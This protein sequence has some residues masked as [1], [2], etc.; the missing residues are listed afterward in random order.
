MARAVGKKARGRGSKDFLKGG[1]PKEV[2]FGFES[3][4]P[5]HVEKKRP[6]VERADVI[7]VE[8]LPQFIKKLRTTSPELA[9]QPQTIKIQGVPYQY[10]PAFP[11]YTE[12]YYSL[13][14]EAMERGKTVIGTD[15]QATKKIGELGEQMQTASHLGNAMRKAAAWAR[16]NQARE[17]KRLDWILKN[18]HK[19]E[20]KTVYIDAGNVH[21]PLYHDFKR[22]LVKKGLA[23][24][25]K[26]TRE[27]LAR[28]DLGGQIE[29]YNPFDQMKRIFRFKKKLTEKDHERI[30][31]LMEQ[32]KAFNLGY[33]HLANK[34]VA[35]GMSQES[36]GHEAEMELLRRQ[37]RAGLAKSEEQIAAE[38]R[39][40]E[41]RRAHE[42][43]ET[44]RKIQEARKARELEEWQKKPLKERVV[45]F[46][47]G[48]ERQA[49][50]SFAVSELVRAA[51][52]REKRIF[53]R[54]KSD[55]VLMNEFVNK[56]TKLAQKQAEGKISPKELK[57]LEFITNRVQ[58]LKR[59]Y[60]G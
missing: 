52:I 26:V 10:R 41:Q 29:K 2:I 4:A 11:E 60:G 9:N 33:W 40:A 53:G 25:I 49:L 36:A 59:D 42:A 28:P 20:G 18:L 50:S 7:L 15:L 21:T 37:T 46:I 38:A 14:K 19:F 56:Y 51:R 24:K 58:A 44:E 6:F 39:Q 3:H 48:P 8:D 32:D 16:Y 22:M 23:D 5:Q 47:Y 1:L 12:K 54:R 57:Q 45:D 43:Q 17:K 34:Y 31:E 13:L 55:G 27:H 35:Q 30:A